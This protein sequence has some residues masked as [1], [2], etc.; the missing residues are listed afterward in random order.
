VQALALSK[1]HVNKW[2]VEAAQGARM[3]EL[4]QNN[5]KMLAE[6]EQTCLVLVEAEAA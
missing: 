6:L 2:A 5:T 4:E 3:A 1:A